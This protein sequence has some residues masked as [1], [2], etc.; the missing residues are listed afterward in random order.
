MVYKNDDKA[1]MYTRLI[2]ALIFILSSL[3]LIGG[4]RR[5]SDVAKEDAITLYGFSVVKEP[6]EN[7]IFPAYKTLWKEK[8]GQD[9][10]FTPSYAGSELVTNQILSGVDAD[11]AILA[12]DRNADKLVEGGATKNK[13]RSL[14]NNG[15]VNKTP[16]VIIVRGGNPKKIKD[17]SDLSNPGV[18]VIHP[19]PVSS[20]AGQ[21]SILA[22]Y[23]SQITDR[24]NRRDVA[25]DSETNDNNESSPKVVNV[26]NSDLYDDKAVEFLKNVWKNVIA[27]PGSAREARTAFERGEGDALIT[28][29]LE[30]MQ[31]LDKKNNSNKY[32][33]IYPKATIFSEHP[34]IIIDQNMPPSKYA[35]VELFARHLWDRPAQEAWVKYHFRSVTD[36]KL[37]EKFPKIQMPLY[38]KDFGGWKK[39]YPEIIDGI[40]KQKISVLK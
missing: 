11:I 28:Y 31:L 16:F 3:L 24:L 14:P 30:A 27:T 32:Q 17:F 39:A 21:W 22:L 9:L 18:K 8:T 26:E 6:L 23:G 36:E 33:I 20:G 1:L 19:D 37:N 29:E 4:C 5:R 25:S 13:W 35:V 40:W 10:M 7:E 12:I 34:V 38:V 15:I 2:V